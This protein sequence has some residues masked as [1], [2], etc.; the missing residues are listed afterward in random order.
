MII[1]TESFTIFESGSNNG[2]KLW[3]FHEYRAGAFPD[4]FTPDIYFTNE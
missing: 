1:G 2:V 4:K 3:E